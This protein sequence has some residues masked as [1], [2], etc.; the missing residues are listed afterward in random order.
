[1]VYLALSQDMIGSVWMKA[2][3]TKELR[4]AFIRT[5][6]FPDQIEKWELEVDGKGDYTSGPAAS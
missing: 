3:S 2:F 6:L 1:M 4:D 5:E